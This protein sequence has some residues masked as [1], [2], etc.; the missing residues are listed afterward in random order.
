MQLIIVS[1]H[2][3]DNVGVCVT[4]RPEA[5]IVRKLSSY[6]PVT[7]ATSDEENMHDLKL[8][9][10]TRIRSMKLVPEMKIDEVCTSH[11]STCSCVQ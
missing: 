4:S 9:I 7:I 8:L 11:A 3:D 10:Q 2:V 5:A 1:L 6:R